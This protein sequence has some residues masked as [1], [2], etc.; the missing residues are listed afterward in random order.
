M[1]TDVERNNKQ[2]G[3]TKWTTIDYISDG[4]IK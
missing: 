4:T 2:N 1:A 3:G